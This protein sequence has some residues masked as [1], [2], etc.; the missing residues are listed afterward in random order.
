[1]GFSPVHSESIGLV[2]NLKTGYISPQYHI[3][4]DDW[5]ETVY[6]TDT[7]NPPAAWEHL[8]TFNRF[9]TPIANLRLKVRQTA[10]RAA[11]GGRICPSPGPDGSAP[12]ADLV[13]RHAPFPT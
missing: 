10:S 8:C 4:Y 6:S 5:F 13:E 3:V 2:R 1:M 7:E 11:A 12:H 9:K